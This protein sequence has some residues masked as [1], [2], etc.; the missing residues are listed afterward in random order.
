MHELGV[1]S[2]VCGES[3]RCLWG[4]ERKRG[5]REAPLEIRLAEL[6]LLMKPQ[7]SPHS[8][9]LPF[10]GSNRSGR[11]HGKQI[12][13]LLSRHHTHTDAGMSTPIVTNVDKADDKAKGIVENKQFRGRK[14]SRSF[15]TAG[16]VAQ[17]HMGGASS[18]PQ[19]LTNWQQRNNLTFVRSDV[20]LIQPHRLLKHHT[21]VRHGAGTLTGAVRSGDY[22]VT[23]APVPRVDILGST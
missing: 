8:V 3:P 14:G 19:N 2:V 20:S 17:L 10:K 12:R 7:P 9:Y 18:F 1:N 11:E 5:G 15:P 6:I 23:A 16:C 21:A 22:H 13:L 4:R